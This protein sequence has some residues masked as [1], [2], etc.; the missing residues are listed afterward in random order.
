MN[1]PSKLTRQWL[2][3]FALASLTSCDLTLRQSALRTSLSV[4]TKPTNEF[5]ALYKPVHWS[6]H[7]TD[8]TIVEVKQNNAVWV[9]FC[10]TP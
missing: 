4:P 1:K 2:I 10:K 9:K 3:A 8:Q 6:A 7:D 5:C